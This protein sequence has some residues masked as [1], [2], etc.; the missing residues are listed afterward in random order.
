MFRFSYSTFCHVLQC[1]F[2]GYF[3][4]Q[5]PASW[6]SINSRITITYNHWYTTLAAFRFRQLTPFDFKLSAKV[7]SNR[8]SGWEGEHVA[9]L[10]SM[11]SL[12]LRNLS[13]QFVSTWKHRV[14]LG[15]GAF[16]RFLWLRGGGSWFP[17]NWTPKRIKVFCFGGGRLT[18]GLK[19]IGSS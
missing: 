11:F 10:A 3:T 1:E 19:F 13:S 18:V 12:Q 14:F 8:S 7:P 17:A 4:Q 16:F 9:C 6:I 15:G 2:S 5:K